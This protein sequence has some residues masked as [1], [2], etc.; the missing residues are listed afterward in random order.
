MNAIRS[1]LFSLLMAC[2]AL[3]ALGA[4]AL[5]DGRILTP[6]GVHYG[7]TYGDWAEAWWQWCLSIPHPMHSLFGNGG[8]E[9]GQSG[10]IWFL[11]GNFAGGTQPVVRNCTVPADRAPFFPIVN[12]E[13]STAEEDVLGNPGTT[14]NALRT[15]VEKGIDE[16][17]NHG[18]LV[19]E[20]DK[21]RVP[22]L[23]ETCRVQSPVFSY[24]LPADN[25]WSFFYG[26]TFAPGL[27]APAVDDGIYVL[28]KPLS[29]G[30]H[31]IHFHAEL[32]SGGLFVDVT[33]NITVPK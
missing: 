13:D 28:L 8:V 17:V 33:Y 26:T 3:A 16:A 4:T 18:T 30:K 27:Y 29:P 21:H 10:P 20:I 32:P 15:I 12:Y 1:K 7:R 14:I 9:V 23:S 31:V 19:L 11:G 2:A 6:R 25:I 24:T 22:E 5:A